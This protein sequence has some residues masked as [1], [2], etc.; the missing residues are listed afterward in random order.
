MERKDPIRVHEYSG[1][2]QIIKRLMEER[3]ALTGS[4]R[5]D[6]NSLFTEAKPTTASVVCI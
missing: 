6:K 5:L 1:Y 3:L 4:I 2:A